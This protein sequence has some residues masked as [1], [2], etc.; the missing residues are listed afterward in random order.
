MPVE[1]ELSAAWEEAIQT[2]IDYLQVE[3]NASDH[4]VTAYTHDLRDFAVVVQLAPDSVTPLVIRQYLAKL[5]EKKVSRRTIARKLSSLRTFYRALSRTRSKAHTPAQWVR[6]PKLERK[7]PDFLYIDEM[8]A[9]LSLPDLQTMAGIRDRALLELLYGTGLRVAE[10]ASLQVVDVGRQQ[11]AL[12]V[13]GKGKRE[14]I[15]L[16]GEHAAAALT[17]YLKRS[18]PLLA[19][20]ETTLLFVNQRGGPLTDRSIRRIVERYAKLLGTTKHVSPHTLRHTFATHL[21]EGGADLRAVQELLGH[22]SLST[23]QIYTH[24]AKEH[25]L[26]VYE[27]SHPRA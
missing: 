2:L 12:R 11:G 14:R 26:R 13:L 6:S 15:V 27:A 20:A 23:T 10:C 1:V 19:S 5:V 22:R 8:L 25:L 4:T 7:L 17:D 16:Y 18:R 9:L 3:K 24:T 21:L